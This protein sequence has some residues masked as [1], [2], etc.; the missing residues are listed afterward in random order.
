[1]Y[2]DIA[3]VLLSP[4]CTYN[5]KACIKGYLSCLRVH[6]DASAPPSLLTRSL[7]NSSCFLASLCR[8]F[9][10]HDWVVSIISFSLS[11]S[12]SCK[13][14]TWEESSL[15]DW[16]P[17]PP[18]LLLLLDCRRECSCSICCL[19]SERENRHK[20]YSKSTINYLTTL[21]TCSPPKNDR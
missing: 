3:Y 9:S 10:C 17:L 6:I 5:Y 19:R 20:M 21:L 8:S 13:S 11:V 16:P 15:V 4:G 18:P 2:T 1:M 14:F 7:S 12:F